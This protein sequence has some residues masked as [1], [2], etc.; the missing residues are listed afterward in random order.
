MYSSPLLRGTRLVTMSMLGKD[1]I[2]FTT[3]HFLEVAS[4]F[5]L[6][7]NNINVLTLFVWLELSCGA[8]ILR[9]GFSVH[10][11]SLRASNFLTHFHL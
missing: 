11:D 1:K 2:T 5:Y 6:S 9:S 8:L 4:M 3:V 7:S 10:L